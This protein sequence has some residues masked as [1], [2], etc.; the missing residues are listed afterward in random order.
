VSILVAILLGIVQGL[1]EF[2]PISSDGHLILVPWA[3]GLETPTLAFSVALHLG[4]L[5]GVVVALRPELVLVL[6][7]L[8]GWRAASE[9]DQL[10]VKLLIYGTIPAATAGLLLKGFVADIQRPVPAALLLIVTGFLLTSTESK[11]E[12]SAE[13]PRRT[14]VTAPDSWKMGVAQVFAL[15]PGVSRSGTTIVAGVRAGLDRQAAA[16]FSF[17][18]SVPVIAGAVVLEM[19]DAIEQGAFGSQALTFAIGILAAGATGFW[20]LRWFLGIIGRVGL[21]PF[22]RYCWMAGTVLAILATARA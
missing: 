3:L 14:S 10:L 12:Q 6:R 5:I 18:L 22:G 2:I 4:T 19:P 15:L 1:S 20:A 9:R 11:L 16:R 17:L 7:T 8:T 13:E 21:R